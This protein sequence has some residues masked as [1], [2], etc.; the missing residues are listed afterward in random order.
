MHGILTNCHGLTLAY[1]SFTI[2]QNYLYFPRSAKFCRALN[3]S[4][5]QSVSC[6]F[7]PVQQPL[8]LITV[9]FL[10]AYVIYT[11]D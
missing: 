11:D 1:F 9:Y 4:D 3:V 10:E 8:N 5:N 6:R 7:M 2:S